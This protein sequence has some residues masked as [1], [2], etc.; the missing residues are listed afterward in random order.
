MLFPSDIAN[1]FSREI[2]GT[3]SSIES[4]VDLKGLSLNDMPAAN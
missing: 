1:S 2:L 4:R 3:F